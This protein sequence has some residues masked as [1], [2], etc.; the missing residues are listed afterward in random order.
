MMHSGLNNYCPCQESYL[1]QSMIFL[2]V[3]KFCLR[4]VLHIENAT[5]REDER[6]LDDSQSGQHDHSWHE[7]IVNVLK[8]ATRSLSI[9]SLVG[10][11]FPDAFSWMIPHLASQLFMFSQTKMYIVFKRI[12]SC[13]NVIAT[14]KQSSWICTKCC[15]HTNR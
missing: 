6:L 1:A 11:G 12:Q 9:H 7:Y 4:N 13:S 2:S 8:L 15:D 10:F 5:D 14:P 3:R